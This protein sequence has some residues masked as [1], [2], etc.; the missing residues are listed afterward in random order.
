[1]INIFVA[2]HNG[3]VG[4]AIYQRLLH[5]KNVNLIVATKEELNLVDQNKVDN[6]FKNNQID[7]IYLAAGRVGGIFANNEYPASFIYENLMIA[8]NVINAAHQNDINKILYLGSS[9]IYPK[10]AEQPIEENSILTGE[11]EK[12]NQPYAISK[13]AGIKLCESYNRQFNRDYRSAMPT[14]LYGI[15]DNYHGENSHVIPAL[16]KRIHEAKINNDSKLDV[17][18]SGNALREF[19][20]V[21]DAADACILLMNISKEKYKSI[22]DDMLSQVNIGSGEEISIKNL[23]EILV[24]VIGFKGDINF[25]TSKPD[26]TPRKVMDISKISS[27]D[28]KPKYSLREGIEKAYKWFQDN[29]D[30]Y[31]T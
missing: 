20:S 27:L 3:M 10:F 11:L 21:D 9:C 14:N 28:W 18:G 2:G 26:G 30:I 7:Q 25:D 13:I 5:D 31:R 22:T 6:F 12:T 24:E 19:L 4:S 15:N 1:M 23:V 29:Q 16:I 17:W 8:A